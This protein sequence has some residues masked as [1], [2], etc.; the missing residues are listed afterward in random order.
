MSYMTLT[1]A[2]GLV[3]IFAYWSRSRQ[4]KNE[5]RQKSKTNDVYPLSRTKSQAKLRRI[6]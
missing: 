3:L 2:M 5:K 4:I 6:K 1:I